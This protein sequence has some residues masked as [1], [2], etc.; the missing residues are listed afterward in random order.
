[1]RVGAGLQITLN[2]QKTQKSLFLTTYTL[3]KNADLHTETY[4][5]AHI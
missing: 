4:S 2:G 3:F 5:W 1:M